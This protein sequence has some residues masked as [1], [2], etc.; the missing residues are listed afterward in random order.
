MRFKYT[1]IAVFMIGFLA[2][3]SDDDPVDDPDVGVNDMQPDAA[4][5][6]T[7]DTGDTGEPDAADDPD[8]PEEPDATADPDTGDDVGDDTDIIDEPPEHPL[9]TCDSMDPEVCAFPWP[10]NLYLAPDDE[11]TTGYQ[12]HFGE[13]SLPKNSQ[14]FHVAPSLLKHLDGYDLG[15]PIMVRF[16]NLDDSE[17]PH[18]YEIEASL[19]DDAQI[20]LY[21]VRD[22]ELVRIPYFA[23]LDLMEDDPEMQ[24][25]FVRPAVIL[26]MDTQYVVAFRDLSDVSGD[27]IEPSQSFQELLDGD[28]DDDDVLRH[29]QQ[30]FDEVFALLDDAGV[31]PQSLTLAWDFHTASSDAL[32]GPML[33]MRDDAFDWTADHGIAWTIEESTEFDAEVDP[34]SDNDVNP[35]IG[36]DLQ[37]TIEVPHY[38]EPYE[39]VNGTWKLHRDDDGE[40][41]RNET[42]DVDIRV[43][44][45]HRAL[46]GE[47]VG[48]V[49]Y[50]HGLFG[51]RNGVSSGHLDQLAEEYG[52]IMIGAD[53]VGM[54][55]TE[56]EAALQG[57]SNLNHFIAL[58]DRLHQGILE[59]LLAAHT[60]RN[61]LGEL[62]ELTSRDVTI[63]V[64]DVYYFGA[65]QG[66]IFGHTFMALTPDV[67]RG[68]LA[69]PGNN[70]STLLHRS[71]NFDHFNEA[72]A[73]WYQSAV[74]RN[75]NVAIMSLM[76]ST[77]EPISFARHIN[78]EPFDEDPRDVLLAVAKGDY[79]VATITNENTARTN[80]GIPL[81]EN[82]D[83]EREPFDAEVV[84]Y[85]HQ[86]SGTVLFDFGNPWPPPGNLPPADGLGDPHGRLVE[87]EDAGLQIDAFFRDAEIIDICDGQPCHID[88][89]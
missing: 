58:A 15:V 83:A 37:A 66:G 74:D 70:Y 13:E 29:R 75:I 7:G 55:T 31:D 62:E 77:T 42:R 26:E 12:L 34:D 76:W 46:E 5:D 89:L 25:L 33:H 16:P 60:A 86:G 36:L 53:L 67:E 48:V 81:L 79:Q 54:S 3:C 4:V 14:N 78:H 47:E 20:L 61:E 72:M 64:D 43:R 71:V 23:E 63:D 8:V 82:Y 49:L 24:T 19:D 2:A 11:R 9:A 84:S 44:V 41:A 73:L 10:S 56:V 38:M 35:H 6:D 59:Y 21:E 88:N 27:A 87:V 18:E 17:I 40:I 57:V 22:D 68:Y 32:H 45:P 52:Y 69:V 1:A 39:G 65:S 85:P 50:G 51:T 28:T 80:I 30:R